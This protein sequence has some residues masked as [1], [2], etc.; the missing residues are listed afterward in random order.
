MSKKNCPTKGQILLVRQITAQITKGNLSVI[1]ITKVDV[2]SFVVPHDKHL[3]SFVDYIDFKM[4]WDSFFAH[5]K[6]GPTHTT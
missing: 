2:L 5:H 1:S 6:I 3:A 4:E